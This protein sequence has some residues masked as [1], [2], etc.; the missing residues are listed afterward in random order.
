MSVDF[1]LG[2]LFRSMI[3]FSSFYRILCSNASQVPHRNS[4]DIGSTLQQHQFETFPHT[5]QYP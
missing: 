2:Q 1:F 3:H 5:N 4:S